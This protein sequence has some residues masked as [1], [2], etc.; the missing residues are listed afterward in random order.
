MTNKEEVVSIVGVGIS[1][2]MIAMKLLEEG[3][4]INIYTKGPDP[5]INQDS[6]QYGSTGNGRMGR[7]VTGF[8]GETYLSD[9]PMYPDM[10]FA[11]QNPVSKGGWLS[12]PIDEYSQEDQEWLQK[13]YEASL[14]LDKVKDIFEKYYVD[15][16]RESIKLWQELHKSKSFLFK[17]TDVT[18]MHDGVLR[19]YDN[20]TVFKS[21]LNSHKEYGFLK[22]ELSAEEVASEFPVYKYACD[23]GLVAGGLIVEGFSFNVI[24][25]CKN[26]ID[27][28]E[29]NGVKVFWDTSIKEIV[30]ENEIVLGLRTDSN[31]LI[32]SQH[33]S[34]NPGAYD[35]G[36]LKN[37]SAKNKIGGV[38]GRW[39]MMPRPEGYDTPTKI[40]GNKRDG[41]P[42]TDNNLTPVTLDGKRMIAVG[43]GY[44]YVGSNQE[45]YA[46]QEAYK[47]I[48]SEN[49]RTI[50]LY[51]KD[52]YQEAKTKGEI[53]I[54]HNTCV[55]SFTYNDEPIHEIMKTKNG[56]VM[57]IT[58][59]TNTG[60]ATVAP[61]LAK[62]TFES[63]RDLA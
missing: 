47:I 37:T 8:E 24:Q 11:F 51:L 3:F 63:M 60:T 30:I 5:R 25:F 21:T 54:W 18:N 23:K 34:I 20:E 9:T 29:S 38:A 31:E 16:N 26:A 44:V 49:E 1:S 32:T 56:G 4:D 14:D 10:Q 43:G 41:F 40:H 53:S 6:E 7:F 12:K 50:D 28:L 57:T 35:P 61:Y 39:L 58:A 62:W 2:L 33:Y 46:N 42:V 17:D 52:F 55:R 45:E 22:R 36:L 15:H 27:H 13:R 48:D 19:L 59:G